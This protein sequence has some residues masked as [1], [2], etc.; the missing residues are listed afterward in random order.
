[1]LAPLEGPHCVWSSGS[2]GPNPRG[3]H[4]NP[5]PR[6]SQPDAAGYACQRSFFSLARDSSGMV[7]DHIAEH[8]HECPN[9][10]L[11]R[12]YD[13]TNLSIKM[14]L[15]STGG[16]TYPSCSHNGHVRQVVVES[17]DKAPGTVATVH[18]GKLS[19]V[20]LAGSER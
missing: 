7:H 12:G 9:A 3:D 5:T 13:T 18:V 15:P 1:M 10:P 8:P 11:R 2:G 14:R 4:G 6:Q 20:D 16:I 19:L 17:R